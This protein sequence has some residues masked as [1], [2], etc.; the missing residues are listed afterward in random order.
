MA[1]TLV[2]GVCGAVLAATEAQEPS[3]EDVSDEGLVGEVVNI[4][5]QL[6]PEVARSRPTTR[7]KRGNP[8]ILPS[9]RPATVV[10]L[11]ARGRQEARRLL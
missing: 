7:V 3:Y 2:C 11:A 10:S 1:R 5:R 6:V 4:S 9:Y 8:S